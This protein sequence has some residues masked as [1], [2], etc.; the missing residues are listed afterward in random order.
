MVFAR[1]PG[2]FAMISIPRV[3][4]NRSFPHAAGCHFYGHGHFSPD[5]RLLYASENDFDGNRGV[6]G[7][8]DAKDRFKRIMEFDAGGIGTHDMTVSDDGR[9]LIIANGG[10]ET[11]PISGAPNS[12]SIT[13]SHRLPSLMQ[14]MAN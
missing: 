7:V 12:I 14:R 5:G 6:I 11:H 2:T 10:I 3:R 13:C 8:Y 4:M 9:L 1:R